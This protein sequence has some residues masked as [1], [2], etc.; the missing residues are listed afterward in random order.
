MR[1]INNA[2]NVDTRAEL[3]IETRAL[4]KT[5]ASLVAV[6]SLTLR[7]RRGEVFGLVGPNGSGKTTTLR[8]LVGLA[9]PTS[10]EISVLGCPP[11][12]AE[13]I[14][15]IGALIESPGFYPSLSGRDNL[16]V[17]ARHAAASRERIEVVL[18]E[19]GL[20]DR[21]SDH[22]GDYSQGMKQRLGIA[23][24]LLKD[25]ELVILD[26]PSN[27]LDP[28]GMAEIRR[29]IRNLR[30]RRTVLLSSHLMHEVEQTCDRVGVISRGAL[31][32]EGTVDELRGRSTIRVV[33]HPM[34]GARRLIEEM[35]GVVSVE[36]V[37]GAL[38]IE[39][40]LS[41]AGSINERL[42]RAGFSVSEL[43][44]RR[45]SLEDVFFDLTRDAGEKL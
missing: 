3:V 14:R 32:R 15:Q 1:L 34:R 33:A 37:D 2:Q 20:A 38:N 18:A 21:A 12:S 36:T 29:F 8:M 16:L 27:G 19:M 45:T 44:P 23:A 41:T 22:F 5:Y 31:I 10:G 11:G 4:T 13:G 42:V 35:R 30:G 7:V 26:E 6:D 17:M 25:P 28:A 9:A 43:G 40:D 24:A 39:A